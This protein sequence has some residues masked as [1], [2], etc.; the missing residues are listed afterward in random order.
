MW[1]TA[2]VSD[3]LRYLLSSSPTKRVEGIDGPRARALGGL[4]GRTRGPRLDAE[5]VV[6][7]GMGNVIAV[8]IALAIVMPGVVRDSD[9]DAP[10]LELLEPPTGWDELFELV[11]ASDSAG[12]ST[13]GAPDSFV[14]L[15]AATSGDFHRRVAAW[16][17]NADLDDLLDWRAPTYE[18]LVNLGARPDFTQ[19][20]P[21]YEWIVD[22]TLNTYVHEW[23]TP[24]LYAEWEYVHGGESRPAHRGR[25]RLVGSTRAALTRDRTACCVSD[26]GSSCSRGRSDHP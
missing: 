17:L 2:A 11:F 26:A 4:H 9:P 24:S 20:P 12:R 13:V 10:E 14:R 7:E 18:T 23:S 16:V 25:W 21:T 5:L 8:N 1:N 3:E 6:R 15:V 22:R 19:I